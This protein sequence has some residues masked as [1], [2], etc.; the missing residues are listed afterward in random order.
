MIMTSTYANE[1][2]IL[3]QP[4]VIKSFRPTGDFTQQGLFGSW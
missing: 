4:E 2:L 1:L 3:I